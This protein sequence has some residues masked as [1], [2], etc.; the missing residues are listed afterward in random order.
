MLI[1]SRPT[2]MCG[3]ASERLPFS[4]RTHRDDNQGASL[5][6]FMDRDLGRKVTWAKLA[7]LDT[8]LVTAGTITEICD[9]EDR[10]CR[11]QLVAQVDNARQL[12]QNWGAG[13]L[14]DDMM[15]LLHRVLYYG[16]LRD[17][18]QDLSALLGLK[19]IVEG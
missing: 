6:V 19:V 5:E 3:S 10:G 9:F 4:I 15:T 13:V 1:A 8:M 16:D 14:P 12:Y 2:R 11:T 17:S 18:I 7:N